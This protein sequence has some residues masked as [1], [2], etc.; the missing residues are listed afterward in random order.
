VSNLKCGYD[1]VHASNGK[2]RLVAASSMHNYRRTYIDNSYKPDD[3]PLTAEVG[4]VV[5]AALLRW[6]LL[7]QLLYSPDPA[8]GAVAAGIVGIRTQLRNK[9]RWCPVTRGWS[10]MGASN[11]D[12]MY[13]H[14]VSG[15]IKFAGAYMHRCSVPPGKSP[16]AWPAEGDRTNSVGDAMRKQDSLANLLNHVVG[17]CLDWAYCS[18]VSDDSGVLGRNHITEMKQR[19]LL[20]KPPPKRWAEL[21]RFMELL[22]PSGLTAEYGGKMQQPVTVVRCNNGNTRPTTLAPKR[23]LVMLEYAW[24]HLRPILGPLAWDS[25]LIS[26]LRDFMSELSDER[27][28]YAIWAASMTPD[29]TE[30]MRLW[31]ISAAAAWDSFWPEGIYR[32]WHHADTGSTEPLLAGDVQLQFPPWAGRSG[33][34]VPNIVPKFRKTTVFVHGG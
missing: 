34:K 5:V 32:H 2:W 23:T 6:C 11:P 1:V 18:T 25:N 3:N 17:N 9:M 7:E 19:G 26:R 30:T 28:R 12:T 14:W 31:D 20:I 22:A 27:Q 13:R 4:D 16:D 29:L 21:C 33:P 24:E 15:A 10:L 8:I